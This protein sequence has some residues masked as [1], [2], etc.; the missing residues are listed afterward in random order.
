MLPFRCFRGLLFSLAVSACPVLA[1]AGPAASASGADEAQAPAQKVLVL[2]SYSRLLP[3]AIEGDRGLRDNLEGLDTGR[4]QLFD[5]YLDSPRFT[6]EEYAEATV[7]FLREKYATSPPDVVVAGGPEVLR[8]LLW[9]RDRLFPGVPVVHE[10]VRANVLPKQL[11]TDV[12]GV[13]HAV[14]FGKSL[15]LALQL[16]PR[17]RRV[18][19][20]SRTAPGPDSEWHSTMML[21]AARLRDRV[22]VE[23]LTDRA[24]SEVLRRVAKLPPDAIVFSPGY[25]SDGANRQFNP[26]EALRDIAVAASAPV[27]SVYS[28]SIG[29]GVVGGVMRPFSDVGREAAELVNALLAGTPPRE[30]ALREGTPVR[31]HLDWQQLQRWSVDRRALPADAVLHFRPPSLWEA[32]RSQVLLGLLVLL[33][34][35]A[36]I[37]W[38]LTERLRRRRAEQA[39][40]Q[41][42]FALAHASRLAVAGELTAAIAHEINQPLGAI[43]SNAEAA[44][45]L[46]ADRADHR[47]E[48]RAILG[49][50]RRD[51]QR[52]GEVIRR[53]R[54]L[55]A[56]HDV[57]RA[58]VDANG[59][60]LDAVAA[61]RGEARRRGVVM[62]ALT[63]LQSE[64][65][66]GDRIQMQ[67]VI[68]NLLMNAMDALEGLPDERRH[69]TA[70]VG[71][72]RDRVRVSVR[73]R[74]PGVA[75]EHLPRLFESFFTTK[76]DGM[77]LGLAIVRSLVESQGGRVWA[78]NA[79]HGGAAFHVEWPLATGAAA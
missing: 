54:G 11:P 63:S 45:V 78:E 47:E 76:R 6:L 25:F 10:G 20:V 35:A 75:P 46:L 53:L 66:V 15:D 57:E 29:K 49:D 26:P 52:A 58:P 27:Y 3:A 42:R 43:L 38:L 64:T 24:H 18:V 70:S 13:A 9:H 36:L 32:Y 37:L 67:Q 71:R 28:T 69:V 14:E 50:I 68:I 73:D 30:L 23:F 48:L 5:E 61:V 74:G 55:L 8:F 2:Y 7:A 17:T 60:V 40:A 16:H 1:A 4:V 19:F 79:E 21:E 56:R 62:E 12:V 22:E 33:L 77:G 51:D 39:V 72:A 44:E 31:A 34:Q 41:Q 65:I 59:I